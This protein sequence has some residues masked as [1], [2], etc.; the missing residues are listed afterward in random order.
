MIGTQIKYYR[1]K[2]SLTQQR[3]ADILNVQKG[4]I[5]MWEANKRTPDISTLMKLSKAFKIDIG[6]L[7]G[8]K[9]EPKQQSKTIIKQQNCI[10][11]IQK[12]S[13]LQLEKAEAYLTALNDMNEENI[14]V[15]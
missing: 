7:V 10:Y 12:L 2:N 3:L 4:T 13:G 15:S 5:S 14:G 11:L 9:K 8:E 1:K 6:E